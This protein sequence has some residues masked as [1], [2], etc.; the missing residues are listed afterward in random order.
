[1]Y[2][3]VSRHLDIVDRGLGPSVMLSTFIV[4]LSSYSRQTRAIHPYALSTRLRVLAR[5]YMR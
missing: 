4:I 1:M 5:V 2:V 3:R